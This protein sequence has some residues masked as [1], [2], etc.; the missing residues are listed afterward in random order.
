MGSC[1]DNIFATRFLCLRRK[2]KNAS[3]VLRH[4]SLSWWEYLDPSDKPQTWIDMKIL[5]RETFVHVS[6]CEDKEDFLEKD[7][8]VVSLVA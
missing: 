1:L 6:S 2:V 7:N 4:F 8:H 3:S 5:M